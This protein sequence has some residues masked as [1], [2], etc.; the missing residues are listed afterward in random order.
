MAYVYKNIGIIYHPLNNAAHKKALELEAFIKKH[1]LNVCACSAWK[2]DK[3]KE[4]APSV[5]LLITT[6][7]DGTIL[8][9]AQASIGTKIPIVSV[10]LGKVGFMTEIP[11][12]SALELLPRILQGDCRID[13]RSVLEV[14]VST[15]EDNNHA[16]SYHALND[17]VV[18]RGNIARVINVEALINDVHFSTHKGDGVI[19]STATGSTGYSMAAGGPIVHPESSD[20]ILTPIVPH[21]TMHH[22]ILMPSDAVVTLKLHTTH[23][24]ALCID[25]HIHRELAN[26]D[27]IKIKI[28]KYKIRFLRLTSKD[29]FFSS[30]E[31]RLKR[32]K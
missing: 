32:G 6:G 5:D 25:G 4:V 8:R 30:L 1:G 9:V 29:E 19:A 22:S 18:S 21:L 16:E 11:A 27:I 17:V 20:I 14:S 31:S 2:T 15:D 10:N 7:G 12:G 23:Q 13:E 24:A 3:L 26:G 28:S